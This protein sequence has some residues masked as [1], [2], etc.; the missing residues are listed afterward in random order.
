MTLTLVT[1]P[2]VEPLAPSEVRAR[3]N[4]GDE[5]TSDVI[6]RWVQSERQKLDGP[7]G[8]LGRCLITQVWDWQV[9]CFPNWGWDGSLPNLGWVGSPGEV[10]KWSQYWPAWRS[11]S[12]VVPLPPTQA[13][14]SVSYVDAD[15]VTQTVDP[16]QYRLIGRDPAHLL[17]VI[18]TSW[19]SAASYP[20]EGGVTIRFRAGYGDEAKDVPFDIRA[21]MVERINYHRS[22]TERNLFI[23]AEDVPGV[24]RI[25]Y[26]VGSGAGTNVSGSSEDCLSRY[27]V[28]GGI[29]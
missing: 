24:G 4:L 17:P 26:R 2:T 16:S 20:G 12:F 9:D 28:G 14:V 8:Q 19:P 3:L 18:G 15:G 7:N 21:A 25:D 27:R 6:Y 13:I 22:L 10:P 29:S 5:V 1:P 23:G 11:W